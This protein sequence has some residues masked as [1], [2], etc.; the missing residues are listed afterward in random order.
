MKTSDSHQ[1]WNTCRTVRLVAALW[2]A[3]GLC[4]SAHAK[5]AGKLNVLFIVSDDLNTEV[6]VYGSIVKTPG[7]EKLA[8]R[9][10]KF[11]RAYCNYPV[12]NPSRTSFLSGLRPDTT[13]V[14]DNA[15]PTRAF[16]KNAVMLPEYFRKHGYQTLKIGKIFH[17]GNDH[18]DPRSWDT[19]IREHATSKTPPPEHVLREFGERGLILKVPDQM[20][21]EYL[22]A[23]QAVAFLEKA[24]TD[25]KPFFV[26]AGFRR[27]HAP[28][29]APQKY[30]DMYDVSKLKPRVGPPGHVANIPRLAL[31]YNLGDPA[32]PVDKAPATMNAYYASVSFMDAQLGII[33]DAMDRMKLWDSTVVVFIGDHG[34]H[35]GEHGGLWHKMTLFEESCRT[36]LVVAAPGRKSGVAS[37]RLVELVDLYP[38]LVELC[39]L[40]RKRGLEGTSFVPLLEDPGRPWKKAAFTIVARPEGGSVENSA[41]VMANEKLDPKWLGRTVRTETW[42]YTEWPDG[43]AE[44]YNHLDDP[45][46]YKNLAHSPAQ[47]ET[48]SELKKL[49][50]A[51]W[52]AARPDK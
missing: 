2:L 52:K 21:W 22:V 27:P 20:T 9:S 5:P 14:V 31:T 33:L 50:H 34:Y 47:K 8:A 51:G 16:L 29:A 41:G 42:R 43:T 49:L 7:L 30:F 6:G 10:V 15:T 48:V 44:L 1:K 38:T 3:G 17:T 36:P 25:G 28:Y 32:L 19:D 40:P 4:F 39:G 23:T 37:M 45:Y 26:A 24:V 12:C 18:E 13:G 11:D 35:L 46:E